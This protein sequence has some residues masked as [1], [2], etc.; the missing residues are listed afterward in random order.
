MPSHF[1]L[2]MCQRCPSFQA[3]AAPGDGIIAVAPSCLPPPLSHYD[4]VVKTVI[5][6][7]AERGLISSFAAGDLGVYLSGVSQPAGYRLSGGGNTFR[8]T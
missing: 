8:T 2:E 5:Q 7:V 6:N 1:L 3:T 4:L